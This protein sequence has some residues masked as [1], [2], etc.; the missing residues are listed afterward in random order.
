[1]AIL[2]RFY[3]RF[4]NFHWPSISFFVSQ[5]DVINKLNKKI[6]ASHRIICSKEFNKINDNEHMLYRGSYMSA[7]VLLNLLKEL[8]K[9]DQ[10][11]GLPS[12]LTLVQRP[13]V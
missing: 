3:C 13:R 10:M 6:K 1:M 9:R 7:H 8:R 5:K 4:E 12:I 11:L 2:H